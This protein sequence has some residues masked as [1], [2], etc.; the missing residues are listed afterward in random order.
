MIRE[1]IVPALVILLFLGAFFKLKWGDD[2]R[3]LMDKDHWKFMN[4]GGGGI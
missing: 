4:W 2:K 1:W 3:A